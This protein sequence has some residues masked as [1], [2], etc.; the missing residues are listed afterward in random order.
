VVDDLRK[1]FRILVPD[2]QEQGLLRVGRREA[3][4]RVVDSSAG[5]FA[6]ACSKT[7]PVN[8]GDVLRL[9]TSAGWHEVR[10]VRQESY[11]DGVFM[12]VERLADITDPREME[13]L[14]T[15]WSDYF[16]LP[17]FSQSGNGTKAAGLFT[18]GALVGIVLAVFVT[19]LANYRPPKQDASMLPDAD[20]VVS[21]LA[22]QA[23]K[24]A[25]SMRSESTE[26]QA[27]PAK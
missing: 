3:T 15:R 27:A 9:R 24:V 17:Y 18:G 4:V 26:S 13:G 20:K 5:G 7:L 25:D 19:V 11:T 22:S 12:G 21:N 14:R 2:G 16:F 6:L 1:S 23:R 8:R 10:V